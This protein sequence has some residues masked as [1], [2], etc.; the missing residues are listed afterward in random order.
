MP[1]QDKATKKPPEAPTEVEQTPKTSLCQACCCGIVACTN[2]KVTR[3]FE[4]YS[5][6]IRIV[7][8]FLL[9][10]LFAVYAVAA[11]LADPV[12]ALPFAVVMATVG[13]CL[14]MV[15][16]CCAVYRRKLHAHLQPPRWLRAQ[17][18]RL[19]W[20]LT[21][22][23]LVSFVT[24]VVLDNLGKPQNLISGLGYV[25]IIFLTFITS[26]HPSRVRWRPVLF[27]LFFQI[28]IAVFALRTPWG[29][30]V[31]LYVSVK[32]VALLDSVLVGA[33]FV[34]GELYYK[35]YFAFV[36]LPL[37]VYFN[38]FMSMLFHVGAM[39]WF[40]LRLSWLY[41]HTFSTT[42]PESVVAAA[43]VFLGSAE[44]LVLPYMSEMT[45]SELYTIFICFY[46]SISGTVIGGY[47][48]LGVSAPSLLSACVM[49][50]PLGLAM[51]KLTYPEVEQSKFS[52]FSGFS[53]SLLQEKSPHRNVMSAMIDGACVGTQLV[54]IIAGSIIAFISLV[55]LFHD[56]FS[57]FSALVNYP[58]MNLSVLSSYVFVPL[59]YVMGVEPRDCF[60]TA[61]V[62]SQHYFLN[63]FVA[64]STVQK[65]RMARDSARL[66]RTDPLTGASNWIS[67]RTEMMV[68]Y[69]C[70]SFAN[71]GSIG[72]I[73]GKMAALCPEKITLFTSMVV[74]SFITGSIVS[75]LNGC[76]AGMI[77]PP[78]KIFCGRLFAVTDA[79]VANGSFWEHAVPERVYE[80]CQRDT[81]LD[82]EDV[83]VN[84]TICCLYEF[85]EAFDYRC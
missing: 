64:F 19:G 6:V 22:V 9:S 24:T 27:G 82:E 58:N 78:E 62:M 56:I 61:E 53:R 79:E 42:G 72:I 11:L 15:T 76:I 66:P 17:R 31:I 73:L 65:M 21:V 44:L 16:P 2:S 43:N 39:Q 57:W 32:V 12:R 69:F 5:Y 4:R 28:G 30:V 1:K 25:V 46:S 74:R 33:R 70:C 63:S 10:L 81:V 35:H 55:A 8:I 67:E 7:A 13:I 36:V 51:S 3:F 85:P 68:V 77:A 54:M 41:R 60:K 37:I 80:C 71:I 40:I 45:T 47:L 83:P 38:S 34:F 26:K 18:H 48:G 75:L 59:T 50:S 20:V 14:T 84:R 23:F 29:I 52:D 49:A